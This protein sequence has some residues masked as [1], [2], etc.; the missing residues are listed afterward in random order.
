MCGPDQKS[1]N[2]K[3]NLKVSNI[4]LLVKLVDLIIAG[5]SVI[6]GRNETL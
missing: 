6:A 1:N 4:L 2:V 5:Q 3:M